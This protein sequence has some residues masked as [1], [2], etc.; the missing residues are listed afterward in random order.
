MKISFS[1]DMTVNPHDDFGLHK[2][3]VSQLLSEM[4]L[5]ASFSLNMRE[6]CIVNNVGWEIP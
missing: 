1:N 4:T 3:G 5:H 6:K 2:Q